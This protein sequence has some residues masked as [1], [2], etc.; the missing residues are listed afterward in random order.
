MAH[1]IKKGP[2]ELGNPV[3]VY[4]AIFQIVLCYYPTLDMHIVLYRA[5]RTIK[6]RFLRLSCWPQDYY[7]QKNPLEDNAGCPLPWENLRFA[8]LRPKNLRKPGICNF[9]A[10][11]PGKTWDFC[12]F[13]LTKREKFVKYGMCKSVKILHVALVSL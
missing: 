2:G 8:V 13:F 11:K 3:I 1:P 7:R 12:H 4:M 6:Y 10:Q 5:S 9:Q